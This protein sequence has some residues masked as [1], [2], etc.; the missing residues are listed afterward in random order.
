[1]AKQYHILFDYGSEGYSFWD[2]G[3]DTL[4]EAVKFA[5]ELGTGSKF[6]IVKIINWE[7]NPLEATKENRKEEK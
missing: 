5:I 7:A 4:D 2:D 3:H 1:M 6:L